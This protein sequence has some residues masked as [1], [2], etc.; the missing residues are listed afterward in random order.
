LP[1]V[2]VSVTDAVSEKD[3]SPKDEPPKDEPPKDELPK[4][5]L[6]DEKDTERSTETVSV[7]EVASTGSLASLWVKV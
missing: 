4:D 3:E 6:K 5:E 1:H 7:Q 2:S